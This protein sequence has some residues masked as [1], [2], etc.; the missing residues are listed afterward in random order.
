V[1]FRKQRDDDDFDDD[2]DEEEREY[3]L[4]QGAINGSEVDLAANARLAQA[5]LI[6]TKELITDALLR[7]AERILLEPKGDRTKVL[8]YIDGIAYPGGQLSKQQTQAITQMTKLLGGLDIKERGKP[9]SGGMKAAL[10]EM[11]YHLG[12]FTEPM[13][14]GAE[15]LTV[16]IQNLKKLLETPNDLNFPPEMR[17]KIREYAAKG[18]GL[19]LIAGPPFSG[20]TTTTRAVM[21]SVD[22]YLYSC[23]S[24]ADLKGRDL[25]N[26]TPFKVKEGDNFAASVMRMKRL[27]ADVIYIDPITNSDRAKEIFPELDKTAMICEVPAKDAVHALLQL[28]EWVGSLDEVIKHVSLSL[29]T[30][31][32]RKLCETCKEAYRPHPKLLQKI[33]LPPETKL[34]YRPRTPPDPED[35]EVDEEDLE[36]CETCGD[37]G[38]VGRI[39]M[40]EMVEMT[41]ALKEF[42]NAKPPYASIKTEVRKLGMQ[43]TQ[44]EGLRLVAEG[45][46]SLE[47]LQRVFKTR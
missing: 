37:V 17:Q 12:V 15:R 29:S 35:P 18:E 16:N 30:K 34:L 1:I 46:T 24:L 6:P 36:P 8:I 11:P 31:L 19:I 13:G 4:F 2:D 44:K 38:Y 7:R 32:I 26:V 9:Q 28:G 3:V 21:R 14:G 33:G 40:F 25:P 23:F 42:L 27:E 5:G 39:G 43:T 20:V 45:I 22:V 10:Q 41:E 47:E